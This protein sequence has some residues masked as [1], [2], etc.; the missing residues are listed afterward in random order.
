LLYYVVMEKSDRVSN[1]GVDTPEIIQ[2]PNGISQQPSEDI[3]ELP[4]T[5]LIPPPKTGKKWLIPVLVGITV[6]SLSTAG[7]FAYQNFQMVRQK[8]GQLLPTISPS[9]STPTATAPTF[10]PTTKPSMVHTNSFNYNNFTISYPDSWTFLDM[11]TSEDFPIKER[12]FPL[13]ASEK[14]IALNKNG[15]YLIITIEEDRGAGVGGI[16]IDDGQYNDFIAD[17][18]KVIIKNSTFCLRKS[19][20][21]SSSLLESHS[22]P[23]AWSC[24]VEYLPNKTT[25][26]G[27][28]FKGYEN[29]IKRNGYTYNFIIVSEKGGQTPP[30]LQ[31]E[32]ITI[33]QSIDW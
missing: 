30:E 20:Y 4:A 5:E 8:A 33:L 28:V 3:S 12:L 16:F 10:G 27:K 23:Y 31:S 6:L 18:D 1:S 24:L 7:F 2:T 15:I 17:K 11:S 26:S 21:S 13:Y 32:I 9:A 22:G 29:V 19:H 25:Q 14:V